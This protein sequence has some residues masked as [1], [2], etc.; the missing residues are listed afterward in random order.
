MKITQEDRDIAA[1]HFYA[2][3]GDKNVCDQ[4]RAGEKDDWFRVMDFAVYRERAT[5]ELR[6]ALAEADRKNDALTHEWNAAEQRGYQHGVEDE[7]TRIV[8][9]L[10]TLPRDVVWPS[11]IIDAIRALGAKRHDQ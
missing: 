1:S 11:Y 2:T 7:Q 8:A 4:M 5:E 3:G 10:N 6:L 9:F